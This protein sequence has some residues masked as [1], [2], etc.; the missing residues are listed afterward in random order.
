MEVGSSLTIVS[1]DLRSFLISRRLFSFSFCHRVDSKR[2]PFYG[3][4]VHLPFSM[5]NPTAPSILFVCMGNICRSPSAEIIWKH[6]TRAS[7]IESGIDSAGTIGYHDGEPPDARM[8]G[9]LRKA[10]YVPF[11]RSRK[12]KPSDFD[13]FDLILAMDKE[14]LQSLETLAASTGKSCAHCHLLLPYSGVKAPEELPDPYYGG[15]TGFH[16]VVELL[17]RA[18][19]GLLARFNSQSS[20]NH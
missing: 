6:K 13:D 11:G 4:D 19:D 5:S 15:E 8:Q 12:V 18:C 2:V 20:C 16:R 10:G 1:T 17:E 3:N 7:G 9:A 14:N